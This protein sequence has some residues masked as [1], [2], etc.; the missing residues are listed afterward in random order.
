MIGRLVTGFVCM[1]ALTSFASA[2]QVLLGHRAQRSAQPPRPRLHGRSE[3]S[4]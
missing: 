3:R 2:A 4:Q 1:L